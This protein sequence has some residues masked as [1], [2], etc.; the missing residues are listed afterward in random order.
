MI[1]RGY[2]KRFQ[3][4]DPVA[5]VCDHVHQNRIAAAL[6]DIQGVG[7]RIDK[8]TDGTPWKVIVDG[9]SDI[10]PAPGTMSPVGYGSSYPF[11]SNYTFGILASDNVL[12]VYKGKARRFTL[13]VYK[14]DT[15]AVTLADGPAQRVC[16]RW[17]VDSG[18]EIMTTAQVDDPPSWDG[19][20]ASGVVAIFDVA[21]GVISLND[22]QQC[23]IVPLE[24]FVPATA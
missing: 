23:G 1:L 4:G 22:Y 12:T 20:Y 18:L 11:G 3:A 19:T 21:G 17:S 7:C 6:E 24:M 13:P 10:T 15:T 8:P 14:A 2:L 5:K 9:T 16:W